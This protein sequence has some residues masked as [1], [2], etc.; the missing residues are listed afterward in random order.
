[1]IFCGQCG[2]QIAPGIIRCPRCGTMVEEAKAA[3]ETS[4]A[5]DYT[6]AGQSIANL[7][8]TGSVAPGIPPQ[9][10]ILRPGNTADNYNPQDATSMMEAPTY[11][12]TLPPGQ[13]MRTQYPASGLYPTQQA[14]HPNYTIP[15]GGTYTPVGLPGQIGNALQQNTNTNNGNPTLRMAGLLIAL[16]GLLLML[17]A[18]ILIVMQQSGTI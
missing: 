8:Q 5:N 3:E 6:I 15:G 17:S 7:S 1:M 13:N 12:T 11:N 18:I 14:S 2:L 4:Q 16:F 10:L 9:P